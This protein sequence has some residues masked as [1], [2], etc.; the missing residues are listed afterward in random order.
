MQIWQII[1]TERYIGAQNKPIATMVF[2]VRQVDLRWVKQN[3]LQDLMLAGFTL[4]ACIDPPIVRMLRIK[5]RL[6]GERS[7]SGKSLA[8]DDVRDS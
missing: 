4:E 7:G 6:I 1:G 8:G 2:N 5:P 3:E